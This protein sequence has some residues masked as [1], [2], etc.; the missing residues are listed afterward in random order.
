MDATICRG[1]INMKHIKRDYR[2]KACVPPPGWTYGVGSNGQNATFSEHGH[3]A[4]Q[5]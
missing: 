1:T 4:K 2:S 3:V 5:I